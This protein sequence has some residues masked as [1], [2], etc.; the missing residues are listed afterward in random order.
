MPSLVSSKADMVLNGVM[1]VDTLTD[2]VAPSR[3]LFHRV[4]AST[5]P[6]T[7]SCR[8]GAAARAC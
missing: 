4:G 7:C 1:S 5:P 6:T 2:F 3:L 8:A